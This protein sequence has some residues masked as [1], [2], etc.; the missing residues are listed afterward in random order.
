MD[1]K[2]DEVDLYDFVLPDGRTVDVKASKHKH[3]TL[4]LGPK[5][6]KDHS[7]LA[8]LYVLAV[9]TGPIIDVVGYAKGETLWNN[10][11]LHPKI[12]AKK[13]W[14]PQEELIPIEELVKVIDMSND[15]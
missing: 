7:R 2:I 8:D 4:I 11:T 15:S 3:A 9:G 12:K 13:R 6:S 1:T 5:Q 14:L 10:Y